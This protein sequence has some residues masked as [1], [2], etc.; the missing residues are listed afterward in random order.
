[1]LN[2]INGNFSKLVTFK[3]FWV[4]INDLTKNMMCIILRNLLESFFEKNV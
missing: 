3:T 2:E 1:M 4:Q